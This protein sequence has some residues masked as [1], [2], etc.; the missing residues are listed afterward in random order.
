MSCAPL[1]DFFIGAHA[2]VAGMRLLIRDAA[3]QRTHCAKLALLAP[4]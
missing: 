4:E 3:C 2:R 1:P